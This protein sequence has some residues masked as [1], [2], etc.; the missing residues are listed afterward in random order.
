MSYT[1]PDVLS[2]IQYRGPYRIK[3]INTISRNIQK[4][5]RWAAAYLE[6]DIGTPR[7]YLYN[8]LGRYSSGAIVTYRGNEIC[9]GG[10]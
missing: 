8:G 7:R 2:T 5:L 3:R 4:D 9:M 1:W 6:G 10:A